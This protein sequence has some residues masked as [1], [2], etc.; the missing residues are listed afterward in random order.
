MRRKL[1]IALFAAILVVMFIGMIVF[2]ALFFP[3]P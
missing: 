3:G 2:A 1:E